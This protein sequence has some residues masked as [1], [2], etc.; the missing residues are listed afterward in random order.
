MKWRAEKWKQ[1][2]QITR[3]KGFC[4]H[5]AALIHLQRLELITLRFDCK[6]HRFIRLYFDMFSFC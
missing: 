1:D 3:K 5:A 6:I 2:N 4:R